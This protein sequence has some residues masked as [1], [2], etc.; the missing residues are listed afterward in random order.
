[1]EINL[2]DD[3]RTDEWI[4]LF[5]LVCVYVTD[6]IDNGTEGYFAN[7]LEDNSVSGIKLSIQITDEIINNGIEFQNPDVFYDYLEAKNSGR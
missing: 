7:I 3:M 4:G 2:V 5:Y 6:I 1:M